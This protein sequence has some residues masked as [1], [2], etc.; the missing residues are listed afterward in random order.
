M[1]LPLIL[2]ALGLS[3]GAVLVEGGRA[4]SDDDMPRE[5][6]AVHWGRKLEPALLRAAASHKPVML[7]FQEVPG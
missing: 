5:F 2:A 4:I 7:L 1:R 6:G 3:C